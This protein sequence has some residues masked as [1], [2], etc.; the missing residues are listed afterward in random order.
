[1]EVQRG[2]YTLLILS[3]SRPLSF[4]LL[5]AATNH[6]S[7]KETYV[8][9]FFGE[10]RGLPPKFVVE[11]P[12]FLATEDTVNMAFNQIQAYREGVRHYIPHP[13]L[14]YFEQVKV[15]SGTYAL[16]QMR[17]PKE[18]IG[19]YNRGELNFEE[20]IRNEWQR[21]LA[22]EGT[23]AFRLKHRQVSLGK[24]QTTI[25]HRVRRRLVRGRIVPPSPQKGWRS[26][27]KYTK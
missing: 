22:R 8:Q 20:L 23:V 7:P 19:K 4:L 25:Y 26:A 24:A 21:E 13:L 14:K 5:T 12:M 27:L 6:P 11:F 2:S 15:E 10:N 18:D 17:G 3:S 9:I 1:M 16:E